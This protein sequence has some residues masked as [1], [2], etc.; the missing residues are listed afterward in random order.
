MRYPVV[1]FEDAQDY[2][3]KRRAGAIPDDEP[4][5]MQFRDSEDGT[6]GDVEEQ[7]W[8]GLVALQDRFAELQ[9]SHGVRKRDSL[10]GQLVPILFEAIGQLP[11]T[12]LTDRD[13][14][15]YLSTR[16]LFDFAVWRDRKSGK[17]GNFPSADSF[18]ASSRALHQD[19]ISLRMLN[20]AL[21]SQA[22]DGADDD[23]FELAR[24]GAGDVWKS[25]ILRTL[26]S[27]APLVVQEVVNSVRRDELKTDV[28]RVFAPRVRKM[29]ANVLLEILSPDEAQRFVEEQRKL[30]VDDLERAAKSG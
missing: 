15:R 28:V 27:E 18:G 20:R 17:E 22:A 12:V 29:R 13:F 1:V 10:E 25:H 23:P 26:T 21:I 11:A 19:T 9:P 2:V 6:E 30:A 5:R 8:D 24:H 4:P 7:I 3:A 16:W 14:H